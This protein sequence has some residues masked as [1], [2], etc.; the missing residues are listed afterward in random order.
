MPETLPSRRSR[1]QIPAAAPPNHSHL[2]IAIAIIGHV[3]LWVFWE[4]KPGAFATTILI[5]LGWLCAGHYTLVPVY[6]SRILI[7]LRG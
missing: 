1:V 5:G 3:A 7:T 4:N 2:C 6:K